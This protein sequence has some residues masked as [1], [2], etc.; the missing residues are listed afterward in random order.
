M[1]YKK[2]ALAL[3]VGPLVFAQ[4]ATPSLLS[5]GHRLELRGDYRWSDDERHGVK[6]P[7]EPP[8]FE[9]TVDP[10][11]HLELNVADLQLDFGYG[12]IFAARA[13]VHAEAKHRRNPTSSDRQ[14]DADELWVRVGRKPE[15]LERPEG[16]T[17]FLQA[18]KFPKMERQPVRLLESYGLAAT[19]FNRFE[20]LQLLVGG[21]VGRNFYWRVQAANGNPLFLR[22][23]NALA[24]DNGTPEEFTAK[25]RELGTGFPILY[26]AETEDLFFDD[27]N[28][29]IGEAVGYRWQRADETLGFDVIAFHYQR[30]L[31][32]SV[33]LTGTRYGGDLDLLS[34]QEVVPNAR[35]PFHGRNKEEWGARVY[36]EW[37][38]ATV[39]AQFT[40]QD[41]AGLKR[42]GWELEAG[43]R[44][45]LAL[46]YVESI[47]PALRASALDNHFGPSPPFPA[48]SVWWDWRKYDAGV[49]VG[50]RHGVDVTAEYTTHSINSVTPLSLRET[51]VTVR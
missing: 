46:G 34:V 10:G 3:L 1:P 8:Q 15:F 20:D 49:R 25:G 23:P 35:L 27:A 7:F 24:G 19:A 17:F 44:I 41:I 22:D 37:H 47:Q 45:P 32:D 38:N 40:N 28:L 12:E 30:D 43:Y 51:L 21:T 4:D 36:S 5:W 9:T 48:P 6:F 11:H 31:A 16:T 29:Q 18:G 39:I 33:N 50:L 13:K 2:L 14:V 26:N 42:N